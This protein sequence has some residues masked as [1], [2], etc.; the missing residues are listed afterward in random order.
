[1]YVL[2]SA[3]T[4]I[5]RAY[6]N[7]EIRRMHISTPAFQNSALLLVFQNGTK[8]ATAVH[9]LLRYNLETFNN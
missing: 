9:K 1:M 6:L 7:G 3:F 4:A 5:A 8:S 2:P